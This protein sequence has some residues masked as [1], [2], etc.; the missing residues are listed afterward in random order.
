VDRLT[1]VL[2]ELAARGEQH[3]VESRPLKAR[4]E[5]R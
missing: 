4:V 3:L 5:L 2:V 1:L